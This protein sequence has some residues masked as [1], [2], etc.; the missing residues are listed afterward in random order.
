M[1]LEL[2]ASGVWILEALVGCGQ[3]GFGSLGLNPSCRNQSVGQIKEKSDETRP[4]KLP[5]S[6]LVQ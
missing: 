3:L 6:P 2:G 1:G 5:Y 4:S